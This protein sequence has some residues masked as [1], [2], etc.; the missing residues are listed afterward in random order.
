MTIELRNVTKLYG[1]VRALDDISLT[2]DKGQ[3][4]TLLGPTGCGKTTLLRIIAGFVR[5]TSGVVVMDG[6]VINNDPPN[7]RQIG[8]LFQSY[9]LFPHL[10]V[11]DNVSFGLRMQGLDRILIAS[12]VDAVLPLL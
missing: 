9:A 8:L 2:L 11:E 6:K 10:T 12:K 5:P 4:L 3:F 1:S 7:R